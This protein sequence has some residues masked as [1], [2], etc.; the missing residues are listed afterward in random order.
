MKP[1]TEIQK[2]LF[3]GKFDF[4]HHAFK[5]AVQRNIKGLEIRDKYV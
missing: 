3:L 5:R 4:S 2:Q 1:L